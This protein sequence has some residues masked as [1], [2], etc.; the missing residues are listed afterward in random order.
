MIWRM[1]P[2]KTVD[3]YLA[4]I[5]SISARETLTRLRKIILD[6]VPQAEEKI[7]YGIPT[8]RFHGHIASI[9]AFKKHCSFFPGHTVRDFGEDL[10]GYK[11]SK[12]TIQFAH[13]HHMPEELVREILKARVTE[14][15]AENF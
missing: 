6:E 2:T 8:Y 7:S 1:S 4:Q 15:L 14:N 13:D 10:K 12:G 11:T 9:A 3:E 5:E